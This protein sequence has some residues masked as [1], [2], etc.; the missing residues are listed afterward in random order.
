M[1]DKYTESHLSRFFYMKGKSI[2]HFK[3]QTN[4]QRAHSSTFFYM[5]G[6]SMLHSKWQTNT[7][8][9]FQYFLLHERE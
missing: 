9:A 6:K 7:Q 4:M 1:A 5:K 8:S 3:W 2:C